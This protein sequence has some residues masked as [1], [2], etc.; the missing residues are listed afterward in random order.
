MSCICTKVLDVKRH[1][2]DAEFE[3]AV[4]IA[5]DASFHYAYDLIVSDGSKKVLPN[6]LCS[7]YFLC[8]PSWRNS[9]HPF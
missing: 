4:K 6:V 7:F 9:C 8:F 5:P 2:V 1:L 3:G